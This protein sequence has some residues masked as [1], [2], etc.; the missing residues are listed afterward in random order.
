M[1]PKTDW[2]WVPFQVDPRFDGFRVDRYLAQRLAA[3][4]RSRVQ[5]ILKEAR[6]LR[7]ERPIKAS[8]KVR[9]GDKILI[10]YPR[11]PEEPLP[12]DAAIPILFEDESLLVI[13]KPA[14]LLSH[15]TDRIQ[16]HTVL[17]FLKQHRPDLKKLHLL[18]RL[19]RETSGV[20]ALAKNPIAARAWTESMERREIKK[21]YLAVVRG[22]PQPQ[23]G[24]IDF[25]IG[26]EAGEIKVRQAVHV[27]GAVKAVTRYQVLKSSLT[28]DPS[29]DRR[30][31]QMPFPLP[32]GEGGPPKVVGEASLVRAYPET[33]RLHQI[34]VHFAALGHPLLGDVLY[35][36][37]GELYLKMTRR[38]LRIEDRDPLGCRRLALHAER[39]SFAHPLTQKPLVITAPLPAD[40]TELLK[41]QGIRK[42]VH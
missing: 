27:P 3:Y 24:V 14:D 7:E 41:A 38:E 21:E 6:V 35:Q 26:R 42:L 19:D 31:E 1:N 10:A 28:P 37:Q 11:R 33:G 22:T 9:G 40:L 18:H 34:R 32:S 2:V 17:G 8:T 23:Q 36:G 39:L 4:S 15:P 29:P 16:L 12:D 13:N 20:L 25:P 5:A 30:G